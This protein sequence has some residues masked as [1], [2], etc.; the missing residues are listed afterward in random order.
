MILACDILYS[1]V[2]RLVDTQGRCG[3]TP[4]RNNVKGDTPNL[5]IS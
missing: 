1:G 2:V 4:I 5:S 3:V